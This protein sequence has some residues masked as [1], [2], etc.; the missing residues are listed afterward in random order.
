RGTATGMQIQ[1]AEDLIGA[2]RG[3]GL[4]TAEQVAALA[5]E[6][7][8]LGGDPQVL[9]RHLLHRNRITLY[10][11]RKVVHAKAADLF[12]GP[13]VISEKLGEGGMGKVYRARHRDTGQEVAL[14]VVRSNLLSNP[15]VRR[16]YDREVA[17]ASALQHPNIVGVLDADEAEGRYFLAMEF[18]DGID[19]SRLVREHGLLTVPEACE[20]LRQAA[21]GLQHAHQAG[22]VHRDMKPSNIIV[23]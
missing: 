17:A 9:M 21:L 19:L 20:Y 22:L 4:Y 6:L 23:S 3:C 15:T 16:R 8:A 14:K 7:A 10:Q 2:L 1:T 13:Y 5:G 12:L 11:L 18:V